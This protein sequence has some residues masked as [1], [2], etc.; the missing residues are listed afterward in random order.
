MG[1]RHARTDREIPA[2]D[3]SAFP[4]IPRPYSKVHRNADH[5]HER[6]KDPGSP[7]ES[8]RTGEATQ[9]IRQHRRRDHMNAGDSP[10]RG[11]GMSLPVARGRVQTEP[12]T[13]ARARTLTANAQKLVRFPI[14]AKTVR[15]RFALSL[16]VRIP[17]FSGKDCN[18][19]RR[20]AKVSE[21][22][23]MPEFPGKTGRKAGF[24]GCF[25]S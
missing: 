10:G 22:A 13:H 12:Y 14:S 20:L 23:K 5:L 25:P 6:R 17:L 3:R 1:T 21:S 24:R 4:R 7:L 9:N 18:A 15:Y 11:W 2:P 19:L 8:T 16:M